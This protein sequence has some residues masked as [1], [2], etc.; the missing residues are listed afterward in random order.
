MKQL[1]VSTVHA[2]KGL[3]WPI[4]FLTNVHDNS[5]PSSR[6]H[7]SPDQIK[8]ERRLLYVALTRAQGN[9]KPLY[10]NLIFIFFFILTKAYKKM[11]LS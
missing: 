2:A 7:D 5:I 3:E 6:S 8:E 11:N 10:A 9:L 1:V 4:V